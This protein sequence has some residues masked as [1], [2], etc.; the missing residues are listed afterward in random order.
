MKDAGIQKCKTNGS[1]ADQKPKK[2]NKSNELCIHIASETSIYIFNVG[3][4]PWLTLL[5]YATRANRSKASFDCGGSLI[6][7]K[8]VLSAAHCID[9]KL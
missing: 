9:P 6:T 8:H 3:A 7:S 5:G 2:V 1:S 4:W